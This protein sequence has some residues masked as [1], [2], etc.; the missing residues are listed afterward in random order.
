MERRYRASL[1]LVLLALLVMLLTG[2]FYAQGMPAASARILLGEMNGVS[3]YAGAIVEGEKVYFSRETLLKG[4]LLCVGDTSPIPQD[5]PVQQARNVRKMVG[6]YVPATSDVSLSE[7]TIY[8]LCALC[9]QNPLIRTW[10]VSGMRAP[11]EQYALQNETFE[12]YR[13]MFPPAEALQR[14]LKDVP[15]GG[16]SEHQLNTAF[17]VQFQGKLEWAYTDALDRSAD[18]RWLRENAWRFGFIRRYP[19]E[20]AHITRVDTEELHFRYVG[21]VHAMAMQATGWCLEEYLAA[22]RAYGGIS[23]ETQEG[24]TTFVLC[25]KMTEIGAAFPIPEGYEAAPSADN[26]GYAV[27]ALTRNQSSSAV[28]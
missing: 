6:L 4:L 10:I 5:M 17:D 7:E 1:Q 19:P 2:A 15:V 26:Q 23:I 8:A 13:E 11:S 18:G 3:V 20:K 9:E 25:T 28:R 24:E 16:A 12:R 22:L 21:R 14:A 27:C